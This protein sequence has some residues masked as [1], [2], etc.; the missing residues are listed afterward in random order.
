MSLIKELIAFPK[1]SVLISQ[2]SV[3]DMRTIHEMYICCYEFFLF[4]YNLSSCSTAETEISLDLNSLH[5]CIVTTLSITENSTACCRVQLS[6]KCYRKQWNVCFGGFESWHRYSN[7][8]S[9]ALGLYNNGTQ[10]LVIYGPFCGNMSNWRYWCM[11]NYWRANQN[12]HKLIF[13]TL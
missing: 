10:V 11:Y 7:K 4:L 9:T 13:I 6:S 12:D 3:H 8:Q 2:F 5:W 1:N